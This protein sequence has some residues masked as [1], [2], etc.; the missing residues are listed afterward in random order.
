MLPSLK[1]FSFLFLA[2]CGFPPRCDLV[3]CAFVLF[4]L[5][6]RQ[7]AQLRCLARRCPTRLC[8]RS[9][10]AGF[11]APVVR[12][13][14]PSDQPTPPAKRPRAEP[15]REPRTE[16]PRAESPPE[17]QQPAQPRRAKRRGGG[18]PSTTMCSP[19]EGLAPAPSPAR[20]ADALVTR[21]RAGL[22]TPGC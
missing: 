16:P 13:A 4:S 18:A 22:D 21:S 5:W 6:R 7:F 14:S 12:V 1:D 15:P 20:S 10:Q 8:L 11:A 17:E 3:H 19:R 9:G 2:L